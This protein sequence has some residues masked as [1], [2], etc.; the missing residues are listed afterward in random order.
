MT[1]LRSTAKA[2]WLRCWR[3]ND[4]KPDSVPTGAGPCQEPK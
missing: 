4:F 2:S 3:S 1:Y